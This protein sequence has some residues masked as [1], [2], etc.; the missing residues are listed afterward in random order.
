MAH[1]L[2]QPSPLLRRLEGF[3]KVSGRNLSSA[4][5]LASGSLYLQSR[6]ETRAPLGSR[7]NTFAFCK[8]ILSTISSIST[9]LCTDMLLLCVAMLCS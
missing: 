4:T 9:Y 7:C 8:V 1:A 5:L 2:R 6:D 3:R